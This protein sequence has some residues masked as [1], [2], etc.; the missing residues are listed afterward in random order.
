MNEKECLE[1]FIDKLPENKTDKI[2][3]SLWKMIFVSFSLSF[4]GDMISS[5][6]HYAVTHDW[7]ITQIFTGLISS[8]VWTTSGILMMNMDTNQ[9]RIRFAICNALGYTTGSTIMLLYLKP[10]FA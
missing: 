1:Y 7:I 10:L 9:E 2:K 5:F 3:M 4:L 6:D 8:A